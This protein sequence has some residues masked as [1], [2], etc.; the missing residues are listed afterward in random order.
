MEFN[1]IEGTHKDPLPRYGHTA[2]FYNNRI[3]VFGGKIKQDLYFFH[4]DL[5][6]FDIEFHRWHSPSVYTKSLMK[7][8]R[9]HIAVLVGQLIF[10]HGGLSEDN[11]YLNDSYLLSFSPLKWNVCSIKTNIN[12]YKTAEE[13]IISSSSI[14]CSPP[15]LVGHAACLVL[16]N[17]IRKNPKFN[18]YKYPESN[19]NNLSSLKTNYKIKER[20][21]YIFGG[22][23]NDE[24]Y[25]NE[26]YVLKIGKKPLEWKRL[27]IN[28]KPPL[29]RTNFTM[30]YIEELNF[31]IIH[32]G[33][34]DY[35]NYYEKQKL[36]SNTDLKQILNLDNN[37][38]NN[39][40]DF[41]NGNSKRSRY[42]RNENMSFTKEIVDKKTDMLNDIGIFKEHDNIQLPRKISQ[43]KYS[44]QTNSFLSENSINGKS[45][46]KN[47]VNQNNNNKNLIDDDVNIL[48]D[49]HDKNNNQIEEKA[50]FINSNSNNNTEV[51]GRQTK[52][53][54][55]FI[56]VD[57]QDQ[58][59]E[60]RK[61]RNNS[62]I[63]K[64][65]QHK[66]NSSITQN[67]NLYS[68]ENN[69]DYALDDFWL[70]DLTKLEWLKINI[71]F[72]DAKSTV[73]TRCGHCSFTLEKKLYI[74]G[75]MNSTKYLGSHVFVIDLN[76]KKQKVN[77]MYKKNQSNPFSNTKKMMMNGLTFI[78]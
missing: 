56:I 37:A 41:V 31:L 77:N 72:E 9:N 19:S 38:H 22:K 78:K 14:N 16:Q 64:P 46:G 75:G 39:H 33:R 42:T 3:Y 23:V 6:I 30:N 74:F 36:K 54:D 73:Y 67:K 25:N 48:N 27:I 29:G 26:V 76:G 28:G 51:L 40:N 17:D 58:E 62:E 13:N 63:K 70:L 59:G 61:G 44:I 2:T 52:Q 53:T 11:E 8:R 34:N 45:T 1:E 20:G 66:F 15:N 47:I 71:T 10:I 18:I 68:T 24:V 60:D 5:E 32:G 4:G 69:L 65:P 12:I 55:N 57:N 50:K 43:N 7:M 21:V 35:Y 49:N